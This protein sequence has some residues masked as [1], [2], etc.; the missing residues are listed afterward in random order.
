MKRIVFFGDSL[1]AGYGLQQPD[2]QSFPALIQRE[3]NNTGLD[4]LAVNAGLSGDT[5][6][7]GL[8]RLSYWLSEPIDVFVLEL[9]ANDLLRGLAPAGTQRNLQAI[10][11][12][13]KSKFPLAKLLLLG[14]QL[15]LWVPGQR[16]AEFRQLYQDLAMTNKIPFLP[17]LLDGVAGIKHLNM[18]DGVHPLAEGY[19]IIAGRVWRILLP[20]L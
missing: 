20:L 6:A 1:T 5:S 7:S 11:D 8:S 2:E 14:M 13:V 3:L 15:P 16:A 18:H 17:F 9:G 10:I 19:Q 12:Q 4:Y